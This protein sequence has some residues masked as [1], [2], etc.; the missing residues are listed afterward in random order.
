M[1]NPNNFSKPAC[2]CGYDKSNLK[3]QHKCEYSGF[4]QVLY[5][6]GISAVP[7][8]VNFVC[9]VCNEAIESTDDPNILK[10]YVGR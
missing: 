7:V 9:T 10:Q 8:R 3:V 2:S 1:E 4:G 5:W 6:I